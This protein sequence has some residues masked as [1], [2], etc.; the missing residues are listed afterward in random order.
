M[1]HSGSS[2][3]CSA[4]LGLAL[5]KTNFTC[6]N[7]GQ[8]TIQ[9]TV[10]DDSG[11]SQ[12][13]TASLVVNDCS[14]PVVQCRDLT[15]SLGQTGSVTPDPW[16]FDA[17]TQDNCGASGLSANL[18]PSVFGCSDLGVQSAT[19]VVSDASGNSSSCQIAVTIADSL[20]GCISTS[21]P[22]QLDLGAAALQS[23][24]YQASAVVTSSGA[25]EVGASVIFTAGQTVTLMPGF[26]ASSGTTFLAHI[27]SC[28][29]E[30]AREGV[31]VENAEPDQ[32]AN[33][34][35]DARKPG[36]LQGLTSKVYPNPFAETFTLNIHLP[37]QTEVR[38]LMRPIHG[39]RVESLMETM[40]LPDGEHSFQIDAGHLPAGIYL[41]ILDAGGVPVPHKVVKIR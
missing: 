21:C 2:D 16:I 36:L 25:V 28:I 6:S 12:S 33:S 13:C 26:S 38:L 32:S 7:L 18:S 1:I 23:A 39:N 37:L 20:G 41:L 17:G 10:T 30:E 34:E 31:V 14:A 40:V 3:N 22:D 29:S 27:S 5:D 8:N 19:L 24:H 11:N 15:L 35:V 4:Q 9:L